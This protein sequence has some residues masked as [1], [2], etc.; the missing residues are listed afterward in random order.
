MWTS[1]LAYCPGRYHKSNHK[2]ESMALSK[3]PP[4]EHGAI[5]QIGVLLVNLGTP[6]APT[7][8]AL[9]KY[10]KEFLS[11][12]RVVEIPRLV[13]WLILNGIILNLRPKKSAEK[14]A[15]IWT[16]EGSPLRIHTEQQTMLLQ[17]RIENSRHKGVM[18]TH[19]MRYGSPSISETLSKLRS[20]GCDRILV[21]PLYPHYNSSTTASIVDSVFSELQTMRNIPE[22]RYVKHFHDHPLYI[23]ALADRVQ[24]YWGEN[25]KPDKLVLSYHGVPS[26]SL[27]KGDPYHCECYKTSRLLADK[28]GIPR[29]QIKTT[30]QSRFGKAEWL[31]PYTIETMQELGKDN[32]RR[33]D[34]FCPGFVSDCLETLEEINMENRSEFLQHGGQEFHYIPCL[35]DSHKWIDTLEKI[36]LENIIAWLPDESDEEIQKR[37][38]ISRSEALSRGAE[39]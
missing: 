28:L 3:E 37:A 1:L 36:A 19:A 31:R 12:R 18:V 23:E 29:E 8:T 11:D 38:Q 6:D 16:N 35:N 25:G 39:K 10:L 13:W 9:K 27:K 4:Y 14:Y 7:K 34:V 17:Q 2:D 21:L 20:N 33:I 22:V 30:F 24:G 15:A 5:S 26:F 32:T